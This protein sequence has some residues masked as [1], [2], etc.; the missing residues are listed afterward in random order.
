[1]SHH[2][3]REFLRDVGRGMLVAGVGY[4]TAVELEL[5]P[6]WADDPA[7]SLNFGG[8]E[9]LVR[10]MQVTAPEKLLPQLVARLKSGT[11]L[12]DLVAAAGLANAR[13]FGGEDYIGFHT[14]MALVPS[15]EMSAELPANRQAL[16]VL[17]VLYRNANRIC[18][19]GGHASEKLHEIA[20][21]VSGAL[22]TLHEDALREA[23]R[24]NDLAGAERILA[25]A[26]KI[27]PETAFNQTLGMIE[28]GLEV[29]RVAMPHRAWELMDIVGRQHA[30]TML[31]QSIHYCIKNDQNPSYSE[32]FR[33]LRELLPKVL[34]QHHLVSKPFG[35]KTA[36]DAWIEQFSNTVFNASPSEAAH[37]VGVA[38]SEGFAPSTVAEAISLAANQLV[39]RDPGRIEKWASKEKPA[40]SVHGDSIGVH[41][42]D[43]VNAL[44]NMSLIANQRNS[45]ACLI[46]AAYE[47]S[48]DGHTRGDAILTA[49][50]RPWEEH[51][52]KV[53]TTTTDGLL[54]EA[55]EAIRQNDQARASATIARYGQLGYPERPVFDLMLRYAISED[56]ALHAEKYYRTVTEEF[57]A[58]RPAFRW[59]QLV[60]LARVTASEYGRPAPGVQEAQGLLGV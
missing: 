12:R 35:N 3:R 8:T 28:D 37:A 44:R 33:P 17:K 9:S 39:L 45:A 49:K 36:D 21:A 34:D 15:Y 47:V 2:T 14:M 25:E 42:C 59:R 16:P 40:G 55:D 11:P 30:H 56:G 27:S 46:L 20:A 43:A 57:A 22:P 23:V 53:K 7:P 48:S 58:S 31:R 41:A 32:S 1:M 38:L 52:E 4:S 10:L 60:A 18:E 29:H 24:K 6:A 13:T 26:T 5:T 51:L 50:S 54:R 19:H